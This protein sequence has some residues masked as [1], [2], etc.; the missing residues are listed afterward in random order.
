MK[1]D[2]KMD[3]LAYARVESC[4]LCRSGI[5]PRSFSH[6]RSHQGKEGL[7]NLILNRFPALFIFHF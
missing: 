3:T 6:D 2:E 1:L 7:L 5:K 4:A